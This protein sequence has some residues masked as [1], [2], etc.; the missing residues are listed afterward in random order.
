MFRYLAALLMLSSLSPRSLAQVQPD[1]SH[2]RASLLTVSTGDEIYAAFGHT[3]IRITDSL[4]GTDRVFNYGTFNFEEENFELKFARG[5]LLYY[6]SEESFLQFI[7]NYVREDRGV[8]EQQLL[9]NGRQKEELYAFLDE[10]VRPQNSAYQYDFLFDNCATRVR[11]V[12]PKTFGAEF[13]FG[14]TLPAGS[15]M[16]YRQIIN[17]YLAKQHAMRLGI[18]LALGQPVDSVMSNTGVMFLPDY[19]RDGIGDGRV[20][21]QKVA[22]EPVTLRP[23]PLPEPAPVNYP[24]FIILGISA[25]TVAGL[26]IKKLYPMGSVL[27]SFILILTG[28]LGCLLVF[29]WFGT[30][31][32]ACQRNW[33]VLWALPTNLLVPFFRKRGRSRY[34]AIAILLILVAL[35]LHVAGVQELPM[36]E[37]G[38]LILTLLVIFGTIY[39]RSK[40]KFTA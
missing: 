8:Q 27:S 19:L 13:R 21:G 2:L 34:A 32:Q 12:F 40:Q 15:K 9:F 28:L 6:C 14:Q 22:G 39:R 29:M 17:K 30:D 25:L 16:T 26:L 20:G 3:A 23:P 37:I 10:N 5:K 33:N 1:S 31:H 7:N 11:D 35:L 4:R 36:L 18:N 38:P 24:L